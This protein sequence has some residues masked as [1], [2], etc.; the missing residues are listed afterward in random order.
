MGAVTI[1]QMADRVSSLMAERLKLGG[2]TLPDRIRLAGRRLPAQVLAEVRYLDTAAQQA[3]HPKLMT[4][5]DEERVAEAYDTIITHLNAIDAGARRRAILLGMA[6]SI[7]FSI[8]VVGVL[9]LIVLRW[10]GFI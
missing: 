1:Q 4:Q 6:S 5:I 3:R 7:A 2:K 8:F 9:L 10:R